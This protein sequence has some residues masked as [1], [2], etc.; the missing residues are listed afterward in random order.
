MVENI[1]LINVLI[2]TTKFMVSMDGV[3]DARDHDG[4]LNLEIEWDSKTFIDCYN[5]KKKKK[6]FTYKSYF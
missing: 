2:I 4:F 6:Q 1:Y 3:L 5:K